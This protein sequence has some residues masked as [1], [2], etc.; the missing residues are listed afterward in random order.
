MIVRDENFLGPNWR[1]LASS[2]RYRREI[3][4]D[5]LVVPM[6][7]LLGH[8]YYLQRSWNLSRK[9]G[10]DRWSIFRWLYQY[11]LLSILILYIKTNKCI[12]YE[13]RPN[14]C[15]QG[16]IKG[17]C[18]GGNCPGPSIPRGHP[19]WHLLFQ[20]KYA[21]EKLSW[22]KRDIRIQLYIP[23]LRWVSVM[24][25]PQVWLSANF[26]NHYWI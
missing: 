17:G 25:F 15:A 13:K 3:W 9:N 26:S 18:N 2:I 6:L 14:P 22:F 7:W 4:C 12:I 21:F 8:I 23:M 10:F 11:W 20:I 1:Q 16:R 24:V 5:D 19:W